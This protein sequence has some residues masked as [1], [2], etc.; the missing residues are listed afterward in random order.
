MH[1]DPTEVILNHLLYYCR[2]CLGQKELLGVL[3]TMNG[4]KTRPRVYP[5]ASEE[6]GSPFIF[7]GT[8]LAL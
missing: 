8:R 7:I 3:Y 6:Q 1:R 2:R 5:T 4:P